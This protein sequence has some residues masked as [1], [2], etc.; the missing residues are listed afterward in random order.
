MAKFGGFYVNDFPIEWESQSF[1][2]NANQQTAGAF[3]YS[4][5]QASTFTQKST[6]FNGPFPNFGTA[7]QQRRRR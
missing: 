3:N 2:A 7:L 5:M 4:W 6:Q 1:L